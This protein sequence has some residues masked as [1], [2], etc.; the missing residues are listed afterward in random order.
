MG[1]R[2]RHDFVC[3]NERDR[4]LLEDGYLENLLDPEGR[5]HA[6]LRT[7]NARKSLEHHLERQRLKQ[8]I[9]DLDILGGYDEH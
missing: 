5:E 2:S 4:S 6:P 3:L 9:A 8:H 1:N 7:A